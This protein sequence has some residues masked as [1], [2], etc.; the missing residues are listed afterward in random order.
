MDMAMHARKYLDTMQY[1]CFSRAWGLVLHSL[2]QSVDGFSGHF[3]PETVF[4][5]RL[6]LLYVI[7][8]YWIFFFFFV[9]LA[10]KKKKNCKKFQFVCVFILV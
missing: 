6:N 2:G 8:A 9:I 7:H 5:C 3:M 1:N 10:S 4:L